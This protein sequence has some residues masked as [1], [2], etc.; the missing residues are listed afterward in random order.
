VAHA[1][2]SD[3]ASDASA[4]V[5]RK[6]LSS[7]VLDT[8]YAK[9]KAFQGFWQ[10]YPNH[11]DKARAFKEWR[12]QLAQVAQEERDALAQRII[13]GAKAYRDDP[14]RNQEHTKYAEGWLSGRR[15]EDE[16]GTIAAPSLASVKTQ[17]QIDA[18][19]ERQRAED[20]AAVRKLGSA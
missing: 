19:W 7:R 14:N 6:V 18:E 10:Y 20:D 8:D 2:A 16:L 17:E 11:R 12:K 4:P 9:D 13:A 1:S 3:G 5:A 15:W